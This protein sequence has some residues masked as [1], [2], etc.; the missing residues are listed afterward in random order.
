M[1]PTSSMNVAPG[2]HGLAYGMV[3]FLMASGLNVNAKEVELFFN[4]IVA[5]RDP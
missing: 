4:A 1:E 2:I 5:R 3:L